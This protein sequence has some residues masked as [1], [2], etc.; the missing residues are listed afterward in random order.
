MRPHLPAF[1]SLVALSWSLA[2]EAADS[3]VKVSS[4]GYLPG[5]SKRASVTAS[6]TQWKLVRDADGSVAASGNLSAAKSDP[7]TSQSIAVADFS[8]VTETGKFY[9]E[10]TG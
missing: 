6:G 10:V 9:V 1:L 2:A 3:D 5:R 7:D 4:I 8:S